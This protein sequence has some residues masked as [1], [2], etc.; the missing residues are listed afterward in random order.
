MSVMLLGVENVKDYLALTADP[1]AESTEAYRKRTGCLIVDG[2]APFFDSL[3]IALLRL[4]R[5]GNEKFLQALQEK[6]PEAVAAQI[7]EAKRQN[8]EAERAYNARNP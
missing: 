3:R 6:Y 5:Y 1:G 2:A 4:E 7:K 8:A